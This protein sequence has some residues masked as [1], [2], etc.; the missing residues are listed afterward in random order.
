MTICLKTIFSSVPRI[1]ALTSLA[2]VGSMHALAADELGADA[3]AAR[4]VAAQT[5]ESEMAF[6]R[7][8]V[9][10]QGEVVDERR[11]LA[12]YERGP[13]EAGRYLVRVVRPQDVEGVT[14]LAKVEADGKT[15][16]SIFLPT[17]GRMRPISGE[18]HA[19]PFLGSE[20]SYSD[21]LNEIPG[22]QQYTRL[23]DATVQG[24]ACY[25]IRAHIHSEDAV[26]SYRDL[27]IEQETFRL[28]RIEYFN[29]DGGLIKTLNC[30]DY[31]AAEIFG[32]T[33]R[34]HRSVM[35]N[36]TTG[37]STTFTVI[38]GRMGEDFEDALFTPAFVEAWTP[39]EVEDFMFQFELR[40]D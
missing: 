24:A 9:M 2:W 28:H 22:V 37:S 13:E 30:F 8:E 19:T 40:L 33:L 20:F 23:E 18:A 7:M 21:L 36:A 38:A 1:T 3:I 11:L 6:I 5:A 39:D 16:Q 4:F 35:T 34:P 29:A 14:V 25:V 12:L 31:G 17:I 10:R 32:R 26:Y 27:Y 15:E